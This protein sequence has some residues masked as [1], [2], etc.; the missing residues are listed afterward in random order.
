MNP[1]ISA[2]AYASSGSAVFFGLTA[3]EFA[4]VVGAVCAVLTFAVNWYY[5]RKH[6]KIIE[7]RMNAPF[8]TLQPDE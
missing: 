2:V 4:A 1:K 7:K 5:K 8:P 6:L 3:N